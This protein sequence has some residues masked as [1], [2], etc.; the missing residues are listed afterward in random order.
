MWLAHFAFQACPFSRSGISP[1]DSLRL[2][3]GRPFDSLWLARG[4][5]FGSLR[6][7]HGGPRPWSQQSSADGWTG[8]TGILTTVR[9][10][11]GRPVRLMP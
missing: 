2:A 6:L 4:R 3:H 5:P 8:P 10:E 11:P 7:A 9:G 1:F